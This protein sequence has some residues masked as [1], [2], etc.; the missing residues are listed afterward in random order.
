MELRQLRAFLEVVTQGHFGR[1]AARLNL[2]QPAL[3]QRIQSLER[4]LGVQVLSRNAREVR[5]TPAGEVLLP[6]ATTLVRLEDRAVIELSDFAAGLGGRLRIAYLAGSDVT[7]STHIVAEF[8]RMFPTVEVETS[9][10]DSPVNVVRL[11]KGELDAA[12]IVLPRDLPAGLKVRCV[13]R[14]PLMLALPKGHRLAELNPVPVTAL[15]GEPLIT[16]P[17]SMNP[18]LTAGFE[19]WLVAH[20]RAPLNIVANEPPDEAIEA[21][22]KSGRAITFVSALR[23]SRF[24]VPG[25]A[26]R[27]LSPS[28]VFDMG[29]AYAKDD[30]TPAI[31][32]LLRIIDVVAPEPCEV[33]VDGELVPIENS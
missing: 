8:R 32:N 5:L 18:G 28:P 4:E 9:S 29:V 23:A 13:A 12:F 1:A 22:S 6:Y 10:G 3:T 31:V 11:T 17:P 19:K 25:V 7:T 24:P 26:Y 21:V 33:I 20:T 30:P 2:T 27:N 15:A 14:G 16:I